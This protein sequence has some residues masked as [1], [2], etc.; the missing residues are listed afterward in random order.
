MNLTRPALLAMWIAA[1]CFLQAGCAAHN[2]AAT[3]A[4]RGAGF[5]I[6][7][8]DKD[9]MYYARALDAKPDDPDAYYSR[10]VYYSL[11]RQY[12]LGAQDFTRALELRPDFTDAWN[13]RGAAYYYQGQYANAVHDYSRAIELKSD[14]ALVYANRALAYYY[15]KDYDRAWADVK[16]CRNNG[17]SPDVSL[18]KSL[19]KASGRSE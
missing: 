8:Y 1:V 9:I 14:Y 18:I 6:G 16:T 15:L 3:P 4:E 17:G 5:A 13:N 10:G 7:R 2:V 11:N 19:S 12:G